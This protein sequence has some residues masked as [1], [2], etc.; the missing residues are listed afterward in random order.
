M[1]KVGLFLLVLVS[2]G[3]ATTTDQ[4]DE[5]REARE[6]RT[7]SNIPVRDRGATSDVKTM[8]AESIQDLRRRSG[9]RTLPG[10]SQ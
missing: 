10:A 4:Q 9:G 6:F 8:D 3:C 5:Q 1:T 7:G 2:A